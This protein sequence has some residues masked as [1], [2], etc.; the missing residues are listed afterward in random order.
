[1]PKRTDIQIVISLAA[2][3]WAVLLFSQGV[4]L[5]AKLLR[6]YSL[7]IAI[8]IVL[9]F[10]FDEWL[11]RWSIVERLIRHPSIYGTWQGELKSDWEDPKTGKTNDPFTVYLCV[12]QSFSVLSLRLMSAES[13][14]ESLLCDLTYSRHSIS[15]LTSTY[16]NV[17]RPG[18]R[19]RSA[20]HFG[21]MTL[22]LS[23][24]PVT[25]MTGFYWT[26]RKTCGEIT[27]SIRRKETYDS[28][29]TANSNF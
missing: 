18:V 29:E 8:V 19:H 22:E 6:P 25:Q 14:S 3:V 5:S 28:F 26:D 10:L 7:T 15:T 24:L 9:L 17:P 4:P 13:S 21:A 12:R 20:I 16:Q 1:M 11:W 23:G 27:F 2:L